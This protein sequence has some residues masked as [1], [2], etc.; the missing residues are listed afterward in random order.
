MIHQSRAEQLAKISK[1]LM[2]K[3]PFYGLF[4]ITLNKQWNNSI[5]PTAGVGRN[6]LS[7]HLYINENFWDKINDKQKRGLLKHELLHIGFFHVTEFEHLTDKLIAN[8]AMDLEINQ[9]IVEEDLPPGPQLIS[10]FPELNLEPK[11]GCIYY[12]EKLM[13]AKKSGSSANLNKM[14]AA[15]AAQ[16]MTC[17]ITVNSKGEIEVEIPDHSTWGEF[18]GVSEATQKLIRKQTE[19]ILKEVADQVQKSRGTIPGEFKEILDR[20][21]HVEPPKFDW[22]SYLR[23]FT[24]G[25]TKIFTKKSRRKYN[26]RYSENPG[27]KIKPK[28][29][30]LVGIDTSGSVSTNELKEFMHEIHHMHKTGT[31]I[32]IVQAD[33]A[34]SHIGAYNPRKDFEVHGRGGT[35]FQPVIDYYNANTQKYTCLIYLTDGEAPAPTPARGRM[36]WVMSSQSQLN[37]QLIGPKIK[38][39]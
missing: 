34:I 35:S 6:G 15:A 27:L 24:G 10:N 32:T 20:I 36:L 3:E 13:Q 26:K 9:Y 18:E 17:K 11:K 31:E 28:R 2:L 25:S 22:R 1:D 12:Y 14:L 39:N 30:I 16:Q 37:E 4:L 33:S 21:N 19:H 7:Y 23:R 5:V 8:I 29:H 38:L